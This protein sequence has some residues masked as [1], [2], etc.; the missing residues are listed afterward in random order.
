MTRPSKSDPMAPP[1]PHGVAKPAV[2]ALVAAGY[3]NLEQLTKARE[4][5]IAGLHGMGP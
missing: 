5:D 1:F 2:R 3:T 4:A